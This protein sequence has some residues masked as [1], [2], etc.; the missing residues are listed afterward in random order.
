MLSLGVIYMQNI[1]MSMCLCCGIYDM[2]FIYLFLF[3]C[4]LFVSL[5]PLISRFVHV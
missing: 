5:S 1:L 4:F 2:G 3:L